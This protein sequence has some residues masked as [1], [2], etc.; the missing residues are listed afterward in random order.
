MKK[1]RTLLW[2]K[3]WVSHL[4]KLFVLQIIGKV[5]IKFVKKFGIITEKILDG[6]LRGGKIAI[7]AMYPDT[8]PL[9][10]ISMQNLVNGLLANEFKVIAVTNRK[11]ND[12]L[13]SFLENCCS[14]ILERKNRGRD[15]GAYQAGIQWVSQHYGLSNIER[16]NLANDTLIWLEDATEIVAQTMKSEWDSLYLNFE[17]HTHAQ[18]FFLSFS[19]A[20]LKNERFIRFWRNYVPLNYR[21]HAILN[22]EVRLSEVLIKEGFRCKPYVDQA[23]L[24]NEASVFS[25][26]IVGIASLGNLP[27][28]QEGGIPMPG[29]KQGR[30]SPRTEVEELASLEEL[31]V[32]SEL[33]EET[34]RNGFLRVLNQYCNSQAPHR[35]GLHLYLILG[36]PMKSDIYKCY[37]LSEITRAVKFRNPEL[38]VLFMEFMSG[39]IQTYM[40]GSKENRKR[41]AI[42]EI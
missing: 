12:Q 20:I 30:L 34:L 24:M 32:D 37:P 17:V 25:K 26:E 36:M 42:S 13:M 9:Y 3:T 38:H 31:L 39:K 16:L 2:L 4:L 11:P 22:G 6:D 27:I 1:V 14:V 5:T 7:V 41:R 18:S 28:A 10:L 8:N 21:R 19:S 23:L 15:F 29:A 33:D 40:E 35:I